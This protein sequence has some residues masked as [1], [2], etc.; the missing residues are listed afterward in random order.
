MTHVRLATDADAARWNK[1]ALSHDEGTFFHLFEWR[2]ILLRSFGLAPYYMLAERAG[3]IRGIL[4][5][6][7][8]RSLLFGNALLSTAFCVQ[9]G[10]IAHDSEVQ[11]QL[12]EAAKALLGDLKASWLEYRTRKAGRPGWQAR[13]GLYATFSR[14]IYAD[15]ERNLNA[16]PRKQRAV[17]RKAMA[18]RLSGTVGH[19]VDAF[20]RVYS[21]SMRNLGTP[22]FPKR[23]FG[24]LLRAFP[25]N[26]D[27]VIIRDGYN[28]VSAVLNFY[29][30]DTVLPYY[31]GGTRQA[32]TTGANDLLYWQ[33]MKTA[34]AR[35][36]KRFDFGRSKAGTGAFAFKKNW[37]F[38][39]QWLEYEYFLR[40]E[41]K[42]PEK[43]QTN[44]L[45]A[46]LSR[47]WMHLPVPLA[48]L[49]GPMLISGLG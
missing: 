42:I 22:M 38:E 4:P 33:V 1:Y 10:P 41:K 19:D 30:K 14:E 26:A 27:I 46:R 12:D 9:G 3:E 21:E 20:F 44:P 18:G 32:R 17:L 2:S 36:F 24:E 49:L 45:F 6:V 7:Q 48:N 28:P 23:Y 5:L 35:G 15:E 13:T 31:G 16:I 34:A 25:Q 29:F 37:G 43:N 11:G 47:I 39:P 40:G 8:Q